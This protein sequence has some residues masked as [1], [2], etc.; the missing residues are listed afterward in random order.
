V[1]ESSV[2]LDEIK[3]YNIGLFSG[4]PCSILQPIID[5]V[6]LDDKL[7]YITAVSEGEAIGIAVGSSLSGRLGVVM[8]QNSGLGNIVNPITSLTNIYKIPCLIIISHRGDPESEKDAVQHEI[9]GRIT[10]DLLDLLGI[11]RQILPD[12]ESDISVSVKRAFSVIGETSLPVALILK[13]SILKS[14]SPCFQTYSLQKTPG[15]VIANE[16]PERVVLSRGEVIEDIAAALDKRDLVISATGMISR[17]LFCTYDR[18]GNFYM[19]GSMGTTAAIGLGIALNNPKRKV[20]VLDGDGS[21]L[22]RM[23]SLATIGHYQPFRYIHIV[24]D[25]SC[26]DT[27]GGQK[28]SSNTIFFPHLAVH[29]GYRRA[30]TVFSS[31]AMLKYFRQFQEEKGPSMLHVKIQRGKD[32]KPKRPTLSPEEIR[33]RFMKMFDK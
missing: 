9:M 13:R 12:K 24:L 26:Y 23:G 3:K 20:I 15:R 28:S 31:D 10:E 7:R 21:V 2:F 32:N 29:A 4:V 18:P 11:F 8:L 22:M 19:Q 16:E 25:N 14:F 6:I 33:D 5:K 30:V 27:T 17:E 1:I